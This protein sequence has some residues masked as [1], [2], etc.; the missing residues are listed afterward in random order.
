MVGI[1]SL[2]YASRDP[3]AGCAAM[4]ETVAYI[5]RKRTEVSSLAGS[6]LETHLIAL[7][8]DAHLRGTSP[9]TSTFLA[10]WREVV[11]I[12]VR[13][14]ERLFKEGSLQRLKEDGAT[15]CEMMQAACQTVAVHAAV[16]LSASVTGAGEILG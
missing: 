5:R 2:V 7:Q 15:A 13:A 16:W 1:G 11:P 3:W 10:V 14:G 4:F 9:N 12:G 6:T 8:T